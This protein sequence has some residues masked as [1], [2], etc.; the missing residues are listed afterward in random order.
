M[1]DK[2]GFQNLDAVFFLAGFVRESPAAEPQGPDGAVY[3]GGA[4][5]EV[6]PVGDGV[7]GFIDTGGQEMADKLNL[8]SIQADTGCLIEFRWFFLFIA[9]QQDGIQIIFQSCVHT[10]MLGGRILYIVADTGID[11][12]M[13]D[14]VGNIV[15]DKSGEEGHGFLL[16]LSGSDE[17]DM[18]QTA[19]EKPA[20]F[21]FVHVGAHIAVVPVPENRNIVEEHVRSLQAQLIEPAVLGYQML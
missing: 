1:L 18:A 16:L 5:L 6:I 3:H 21:M 2:Q 14:G 13:A 15:I 12:G 4:D 19:L 7:V 11:I 17:A 9:P 10:V 8:L 20:D